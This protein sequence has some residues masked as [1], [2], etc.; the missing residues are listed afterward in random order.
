MLLFYVW[1][2][3][4]RFRK[5]FFEAEII[6]SVFYVSHL[7]CTYIYIYIYLFTYIHISLYIYILYIPEK[8]GNESQIF[9]LSCV[10]VVSNS[11]VLSENFLAVRKIYD[12]F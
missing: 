4:Y 10:F 8:G 11:I 5:M 6:D 7:D 3:V 12:V 2:V 1:V 9:L